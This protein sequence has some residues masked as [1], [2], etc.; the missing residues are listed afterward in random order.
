M[1]LCNVKVNYINNSLYLAKN[2]LGYY[3]YLF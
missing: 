3:Y 1:Y 2:M